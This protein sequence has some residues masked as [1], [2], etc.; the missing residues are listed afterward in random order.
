MWKDEGDAKLERV[1]ME[2]EGIR[3]Q[4]GGDTKANLKRAEPLG[5][6]LRKGM[7]S[8]LLRPPS[9]KSTQLDQMHQKQRFSVIE[10][11]LST[12]VGLSFLDFTVPIG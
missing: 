12:E 10:W 11:W 7:G 8:R 4:K 9:W 3:K 5:F 1:E 6:I 2:R